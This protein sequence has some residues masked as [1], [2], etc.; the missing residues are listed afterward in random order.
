MDYPEAFAAVSASTWVVGDSYGVVFDGASVGG[1]PRFLTL[2]QVTSI[3]AGTTYFSIA[4]ASGEIVYF[5]ATSDVPLGTIYFPS[6]QL[7]MSTDG[8]VLA[9][10]A[11]ASPLQNPPNTIVNVYSLP[12]A[13]LANTFPIELRLPSPDFGLRQRKRD[14]HVSREHLRVCC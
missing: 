7:S 6:S 12:A 9:A 2:G 13:T 11:V 14:R 3:A 8:K 5:D 4:T 10:A 1:Q